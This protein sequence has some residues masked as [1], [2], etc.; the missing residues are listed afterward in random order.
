MEIRLAIIDDEMTVCRELSKLFSKEDYEVESFQ[1]G[2]SFLDRMAQYPFH[3]VFIDIRLPD[4]DGFEILSRIKSGYEDCEAII[5]TGVGS[6]ESAVRAMKNGAYHFVTKPFRLQEVRLLANNAK[7]KI[8]LRLENRSLREALGENDFMRG[9]IG[10]SPAMQTVF[11]TIR[12]V[13][14]IDCNVLLQAETGTGKEMA[15]RAIHSLSPLNH[16][17]FVSF[18]CGGFTEELI[19]TELFGHEKGGLYRCHGDQGRT[20]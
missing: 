11:S 8:A 2:K 14:S 15:A 16:M 4:M 3:V 20:S 13:A 1:T 7:E 19:C 17:P 5:I 10:A 12:K 18:N 6:I 9:F